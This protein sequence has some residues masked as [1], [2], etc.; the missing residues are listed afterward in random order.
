MLMAVIP[1][2]SLPGAKQRLAAALPAAARRELV[3]RMLAQ[4]LDA[5]AAA[6]IA[7]RVVA[8]RDPALAALATGRGAVVFDPGAEGDLNAAATACAAY[9]KQ[10]GAMSL[11]LLAGD[12]PWIAADD[13][14]ALL[15]AASEAKVVI[16]EAKDGGTNALLLTPPDAIPFAFATAAPSAARHAELAV[17][18]GLTVRTIRRPGLARDIDLPA[19][20]ATLRAEHAAYRDLALV[21]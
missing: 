2:K 3:C 9:A 19:D 20:L 11:L 5:L 4:A 12:L 18:R 1:V 16:A 14:G 7:Q 10:Q 17:A 15:D 8:T 13:V 21:A 6:G